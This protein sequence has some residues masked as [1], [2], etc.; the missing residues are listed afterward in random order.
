[1]QQVLSNWNFFRVIRLALGVFI[2]AQGI[3]NKDLFSITM[4][5]L[6]AGLAV[7]NIGCCGAGGC[8]TDLPKKSSSTEIET[9]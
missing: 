5:V 3:I 4:G 8:A 7:F 2:I 6:F 1:M 9:V